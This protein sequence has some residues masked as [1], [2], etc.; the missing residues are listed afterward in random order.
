M[1]PDKSDQCIICTNSFSNKNIVL[2]NECKHYFCLKCLKR[3]AIESKNCPLDRQMI[4][5]ITIFYKNENQ[6]KK[7]IFKS[8]IKEMIMKK[9]DSF[10]SE[11]HKIIIDNLHEILNLN[12]CL[13]ETLNN[14]KNISEMNS[15]NIID[16]Q[17]KS[18]EYYQ[19]CITISKLFDDKE[20]KS[21]SHNNKNIEENYMILLKKY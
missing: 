11:G 6:P 18:L 19:K 21:F 4:K 10:L 16:F 17:S 9:L 8:F 3:W 7:F 15:E 5:S 2:I 12:N 13:T 1:L 20:I 14:L